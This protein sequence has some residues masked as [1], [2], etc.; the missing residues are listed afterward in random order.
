VQ[1]IHLLETSSMSKGNNSFIESFS[2]G[3]FSQTVWNN[4]IFSNK[5][6][7]HQ[8]LQFLFYGFHQILPLQCPLLCVQVVKCP[9]RANEC[10]LFFFVLRRIGNK[11]VCKKIF[12]I[13]F[14][15]TKIIGVEGRQGDS[16]LKSVKFHS[17]SCLSF[18]LKVKWESHY[19]FPPVEAYL[20]FQ[21]MFSNIFFM[22]STKEQ[23]S[24]SKAS[25]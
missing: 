6:R 2:S 20:I 16:S 15:L 25:P 24:F 7:Y 19:Y 14:W 22:L 3:K 17:V 8:S 18:P 13:F 1:E 9:V 21:Y 10:V 5:N 4:R 11:T 23:K 12:S